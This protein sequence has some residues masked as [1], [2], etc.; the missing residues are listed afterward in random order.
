MSTIMQDYRKALIDQKITIQDLFRQTGDFISFAD[1][2]IN[3]KPVNETEF[4]N[5]LILCL[6]VY[7]FSGNGKVLIPDRTYDRC[8]SVW[9]SLGHKTIVYPD[10]L[11]LQG[12]WEFMNHEIP[13]M[14]GT[15]PKI[16]EYQE[17]KDWFN[18]M[19][20]RGVVDFIL[21]PKYDGISVCIK[22]DED[23]RIEY[24]LTRYDGESGQNVAPTIRLASNVLDFWKALGSKPTPGYY[25]CE[26]I[27][28]TE[29]FKELKEEKEYSNRRSAT[30]GIINTPSNRMLGKY[31]TIVPLLFYNRKELK[32]LAPYQ[33][34]YQFYTARDM[35]DQLEKL[36]DR[37]RATDFFSR[38]DGVVIYP[39][40]KEL[41]I[42][43][44]N[45]MEHSTAFKM[46]TAEGKTQVE[47]VYMTVGRL[48]NAIPMARVRPV[49]VN[50]TIVTDVSLGSV[51]K[52]N[53]LGLYEGEEV[54]IYS[55]GDA[56]PQLKKTNYA[57][58]VY[59][60][61]FLKLVKECPYCHEKLERFGSEYRC[62]N[63]DCLRVNS[64][65]IVNFASKL[66]MQGFSDK[67]FE[68]FYEAGL[69]K[70]IPDLFKVTEE[71]I[72]KV[73]GYEQTSAH[74]FIEEINK[75]RERKIPI[76]EFFGA[77]G[78]PGISKKKCAKIFEHI[79][80]K[81]LLSKIKRD[82]LIF[83]LINADGVGVKTAEVFADFVIENQKLIA[84][85]VEALDVIGDVRMN[86]SVVFTGFRNAKWAEKFKNIG[87]IVSDTVTN[88]TSAVVSAN[89]DWSS[90]KCKAALKKGIPIY[91]YGELDE[92]YEKL[93]G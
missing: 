28:S 38:V 24:A 20:D 90:T 15:L 88:N 21:A 78:I 81:D 85:T 31:L 27:V 45:L 58:N 63:P 19:R 65:R 9:N 5:F 18:A 92:L 76:S 13:G 73:E 41:E 2:V 22:L 53:S 91:L 93:K 67:T 1:R 11:N 40:S 26:I 89:T 25:K 10:P 52:F 34:T 43:E 16:Y 72:C 50:E 14:V 87:Y 30:S 44:G 82:D 59:D 3:G 71:A 23:G 17:L 51:E 4:E 74:N 49:E 35:M 39:V 83:H 70:R 6:D 61:P 46:N 33:N 80:L 56:I 54:I 64:G 47:F 12:K 8:M 79:S 29:S 48:G 66:G 68:D 69:I 42:D 86:G 62:T 77:L 60:R 75:I 84:D 32:Y 37:W 57:N 55:A 36:L 7:A